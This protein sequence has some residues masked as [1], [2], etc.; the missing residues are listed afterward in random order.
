MFERIKMIRKN[1]N[2]NQ[3][4]FG[5]KI[6]LT[7]SGVSKLEKGINNPTEQT[8]L[9]ICREFNVNRKWLETGEG[10]MFIILSPKERLASWMGSV[11]RLDDDNFKLRFINVLSELNEDEWELLEKMANKLVH[12]KRE[13]D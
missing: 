8:I 11:I 7:K 1:L 6:G 12:K 5:S 3:D 9:S 13:A 2:F 4:E 10:E